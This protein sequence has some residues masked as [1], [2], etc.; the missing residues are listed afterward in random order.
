MCENTLRHWDTRCQLHNILRTNCHFIGLSFWVS[1]AWIFSLLNR[2]ISLYTSVWLRRLST[3]MCCVVYFCSLRASSHYSKYLSSAQ[4]CA[5]V[6]QT[7]A[8]VVV[9]GA[10]RWCASF[11]DCQRIIG[12]MLHSKMAR[13]IEICEF[14]SVWLA[15]MLPGVRLHRL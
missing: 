6:C 12:C 8:S 5:V 3:I 15:A 2:W 7:T 1:I 9:V 13:V 11:Q 10:T 14:Q 4:K